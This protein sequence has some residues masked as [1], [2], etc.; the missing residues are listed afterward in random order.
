MVPVVTS[1]AL[2]TKTS[3]PCG[4]RPAI[5]LRPDPHRGGAV[6]HRAADLGQPALRHRELHQDGVELGQRGDGGVFRLADEIAGP[7]RDGAELA[8]DLGGD[9]GEADID[10]GL[11]DQG[12]VR[13][14][15]GGGGGGVR[16]R[17]LEALLGGDAFAAQLL[18][19]QQVGGVAGQ[20]RAV[21]DQ[22][23]L[24]LRQ[25][26]AV[27]A[28]VLDE[29]R[30]ALLHQLAF[31]DQH[32][33]DLAIHPGAHGDDGFRGDDA[34]GQDL[35]RHRADPHRIGGDRYAT[36]R[37]WAPEPAAPAPWASAATAGRQ[38]S[39]A[40]MRVRRNSGGR[41]GIIRSVPKR[42]TPARP[43]PARPVVRRT[44][45]PIRKNP[46]RPTRSVA[47]PNEWRLRPGLGRRTWPLDVA[48]PVPKYL[49]MP[50]LQGPRHGRLACSCG[51]LSADSPREAAR[52]MRL[53]LLLLGL[54]LASPQARAQDF[55]LP[56]L[57][58]EA[59]GYQ[60]D[61]GRRFPAGATP[62]QRADGRGTRRPGGAG[63]ELGRRRP[64]LGGTGRR[65]RGAAGALAGPGP[66]AAAEDPAGC[67][68]GAAGGLDEF[69]DGARPGRRRSPACWSSPRRCSG[70]TARRSSSRRCRP[71]CS[72]RPTT[73][74]TARPWPR[75][76]APPG[77]WS[78]GST[79]NPRR[80]RPAPA[81]ASPSPWRSAPT[82][83]RR[84]GCGRNRRSPASRCC[85]RASSSASPACRMGNPPAS[86]CAP[87]CRRRTGCG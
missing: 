29:Q 28:A 57:S 67:R 64:G 38:A 31:L 65:R 77:C 21:L 24:E 73:R 14:D 27:E 68:P 62:Q 86:S 76:A 32:L 19:A 75:R 16:L 44:S 70:S 52:P 48:T 1:T 50:I 58:G 4:R 26:G 7:Q 42:P 80:S 49:L 40:A 46:N 43:H 15:L 87:A 3:L 84:T 45:Y 5:A 11:L 60:R 78:P 35:D 12:L 79:P 61:L 74:A 53:L 18:V 59:G 33:L 22:V 81:C 51:I 6:P 10:L 37:P 56:G 47:W 72:G 30:L 17:L 85:G 71:C 41:R 63:A 54:L 69:P 66:G 36:A 2:S 39:R 13:L 8:V 83:S 25:Q 23:R 9:G 34:V 55:D 20:Q 82:G